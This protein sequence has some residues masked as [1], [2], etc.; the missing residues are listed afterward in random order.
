MCRI[1]NVLRCSAVEPRRRMLQWNRVRCSS[2]RVEGQLILSCRNSKLSD[3][4]DLSRPV[5]AWPTRQTAVE[6]SQFALIVNRSLFCS[7]IGGDTHVDIVGIEDSKVLPVS[8]PLA[9]FHVGDDAAVDSRM[10][11]PQTFTWTLVVRNGHH[12]GFDLWIRRPFA[13]RQLRYAL[14]GARRRAADSRSI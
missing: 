3:H 6:L 13:R 9:G 5:G 11:K 4:V 2:C 12:H 10:T 14:V 1:H 7:L 8:A